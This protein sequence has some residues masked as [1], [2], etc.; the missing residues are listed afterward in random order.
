V[1][2]DVSRLQFFGE[3][4]ERTDVRCY[5]VHGDHLGAATKESGSRASPS[6]RSTRATA[7][8]L[9]PRFQE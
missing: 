6:T 5:P 2:A 1:A 3:Q 8:W 9:T 7:D 4:M